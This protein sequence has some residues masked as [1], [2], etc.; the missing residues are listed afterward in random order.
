[1]PKKWTY[2]L[3]YMYVNKLTTVLARFRKFLRM[4]LDGITDSVRP[5]CQTHCATVRGRQEFTVGNKKGAM[6]TEVP[7]RG[8]GV[9]LRWDLWRS[10]RKLETKMDVQGGPAKELSLIHI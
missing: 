6:G 2:L 5:D 10:P 4:N 9:Q 7:Q 1:M 8:P 3:T